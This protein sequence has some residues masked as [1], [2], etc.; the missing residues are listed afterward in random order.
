MLGQETGERVLPDRGCSE[1]VKAFDGDSQPLLDSSPEE[2]ELPDLLTAMD[3]QS[4][5]RQV[6]KE[7]N[8][9]KLRDRNPHF[10][11]R[12]PQQ[13]YILAIKTNQ[14]PVDFCLLLVHALNFGISLQKRLSHA[15]ILVRSQSEDAIP[16]YR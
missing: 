15:Q 6:E 2:F 13:F 10:E 8:S 14:M 16:G 7:R 1:E 5:A 9:D 3:I 11:R 12:E 4:Q